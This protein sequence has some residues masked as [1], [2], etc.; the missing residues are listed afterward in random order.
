MCVCLSLSLSF[1]V[2]FLS[3]EVCWRVRVFHQNPWGRG[4][5]LKIMISSFDMFFNCLMLCVISSPEGLSI[6]W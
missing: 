2:F 5:D 6:K 3:L 4:L 1:R